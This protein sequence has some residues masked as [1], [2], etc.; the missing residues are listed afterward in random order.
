MTRWRISPAD[1][2]REAAASVRAQGVRSLLVIAGVIVAAATLVTTSGLSATLSKQVSAEF[3]G[4]QATEIVVGEA[5]GSDP[6]AWT[7]TSDLDRV[8]ALSGVVHAGVMAAPATV[9][10][11]RPPRDG[12]FELPVQPVDAGALAAIGPRLVAGSVFNPFHVRTRA[13]VL[14][15]SESAARRA[16]VTRPGTMLRVSGTEMTVVAV[17]ADVN[18]QDQVMIGA[19]APLGALPAESQDGAR[20]LIETQPG[21]AAAVHDRAALALLPERSEALSASR[22]LDAS[23]FRVGI[24]SR[25]RTLVLAVVGVA[26]V[27]GTI[28]IASSAVSSVYARTAEL[29]LRS[30]LG[31]LRRHVFAQIMAET[32]VLGLAGAAIGAFLG[33]AV[34]VAT[35]TWQGWRPVLDPGVLGLALL[36]GAFAG[37]IAGVPPAWRAMRLQPVDALRRQ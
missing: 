10:A 26:M 7:E 3:D 22:P 13:P 19:L 27:M 29:G 23:G 8:R 4:Y 1:L 5:P 18:R 12:L 32:L 28:S 33:F 37:L 24:E 36:S 2:A 21:A 9:L 14:M 20:V 17:Y 11:E 31:A 35:C 34:L 16:G 15:L 25:V 30:V 6:P